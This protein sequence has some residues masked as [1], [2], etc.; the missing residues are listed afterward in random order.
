M[1]KTQSLRSMIASAAALTPRPIDDGVFEMLHTNKA[2]FTGIISVAFSAFDRK[3]FDSSK[4]RR[5]DI[6][7]EQVSLR[8]DDGAL[9]N[10]AEL[11]ELRS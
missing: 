10:E 2:P 11:A 3:L 1:G 9:M 4:P 6:V 8:R 7:Y 5:S